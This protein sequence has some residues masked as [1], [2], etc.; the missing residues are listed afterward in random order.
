[1]IQ[2]LLLSGGDNEG[3]EGGCTVCESE[4][5]VMLVKGG[6]QGMSIEG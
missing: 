5:G 1:M 2:A 6:A 3:D 4:C